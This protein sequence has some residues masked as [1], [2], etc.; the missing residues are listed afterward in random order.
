MT[1]ITKIHKHIFKDFLEKNLVI[2]IYNDNYNIKF[3]ENYFDKN[4]YFLVLHLG[5]LEYYHK[6]SNNVLIIGKN[7]VSQLDIIKFCRL[8][9]D[10]NLIN[11]Y[12]KEIKSL[13]QT[14]WIFKSALHIYYPKIFIEP[15][16]YLDPSLINFKNIQNMNIVKMNIVKRYFLDIIS[17]IIIDIKTNK[18]DKKYNILIKSLS[19]LL[20]LTNQNNLELKNQI[21]KNNLNQYLKYLYLQVSN[22][23]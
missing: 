23:L 13:K 5:N 1:I 18:I 17:K 21:D 16:I 7:N 11:Y 2:L 9:D 4:Y 12:G 20:I 10:D 22:K 6:I 15:N 3:D 8:Y 14:K 19:N